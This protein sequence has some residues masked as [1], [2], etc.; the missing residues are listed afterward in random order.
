MFSVGERVIHPGQG[1][2]TVAELRDGAE[3]ML[4]LETG[5]GHGTTRLLFPLAQA[6][7][8]LHAPVS[9]AGALEAIDGYGTLA[10]DPYANRN[11]G[12]EEAYFKS[13]VKRGIPDSLR[14]VKTLSRRIDE[15]GRAG[16][17][18]STYLPR[19]LR[20]ARRRSLEELA[21]ALA[22]EPEQVSA[23]FAER[24][25]EELARPE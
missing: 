19:L 16:R 7:T 12:L 24:G 9:A 25:C 22:L 18:P 17:K 4:V 13:L 20:E 21:F 14:A 11:S 8:H 15:A 10:C 3:P 5:R 2:C 1:L 23:M 6:E